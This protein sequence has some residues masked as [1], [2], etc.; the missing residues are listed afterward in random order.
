MQNEQSKILK[1]AEII[2][3]VLIVI[4]TIHPIENYDFWFHIK[5][6][7]YIVKTHSLPFTDVFSHTA[8][9]TPATPYEW[10]FQVLIYFVFHVLGK[11]GVQVMIVTLT[12]SY[13]L[14]FRRILIKIFHLGI[15]SRMTLVSGLYLLGYNFWVERPQ[16]VAYLLFM[17]TLYLVLARIYLHQSKL[18]LV[19]ILF[20]I[21]TNLHASMI[22]GLYLLYAFGFFFL[23]RFIKIRQIS[24]KKLAQDFL[25]WGT[26]GFFATILPPLGIKVYQLLYLFFQKRDFISKAI[27]EWVP[28]YLLSLRYYIY[29]VI[30][31]ITAIALI[32]A[33][34]KKYKRDQ[35]LLFL[36]FIPL[37]LFVLTGVR[38][39]P[40][41]IP[42]TFL[43]FVPALQTIQI[44]FNKIISWL[45]ASTILLLSLWGMY[46]YHNLI[47]SLFKNYPENA[48]PFIRQNLKGN[49]FNEYNVGGYIMYKLGPELKTFIDGRTDMFLPRVLPEYIYFYHLGFTDDDIYLSI[50]DKLV[51]KYHISWAILATNRFSLS[52]RLGRILGNDKSWHLVYFDDA[53]KIYIKDDGI[54]K[55]VIT[56]Y[57]LKAVTPLG[58][59]LYRKD[60][61]E[62][63][64]SEYQEMYNRQK[65][66]VSANA[67]GF[68][69]LE[70]GKFD[71]ARQLFLQALEIKPDAA[72]PK[73]NLAELKANNGDYKEA[74]SLYRQAIKDEPD[75]GLAYLRL[76]QLIIDSG[77]DKDEAKE[78]W[79]KGL[80]ATP[81]QEILAKIRKALQKL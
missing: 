9:G 45:L 5:Y 56:Q 18:W 81:D 7:E 79:K 39:T 80:S 70:D 8:Y 3:F 50:F 44:K 72:A 6:G 61:R 46:S 11:F 38:H 29:L 35:L 31:A 23:V 16:L 15:L 74:M 30:F 49:M 43:L 12:L 10:L 48:I 63:A 34:I 51:E 64:R 2:L 1:I 17:V 47:I 27:D 32:F 4:F 59:T 62:L 20:L 36:P 65:S 33:F 25:F 24:D 58:K 75:R 42:V 60:L 26:L 53:T 37:A 66:A 14:L 77:G 22:V 57:G 21:W 40:F 68:I 19:P 71:E 76:G 13:L 54:N 28:L 69:L 78:I 73:M 41:T 52:W 67:L 55:D